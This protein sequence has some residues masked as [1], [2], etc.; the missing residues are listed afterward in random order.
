MLYKFTEIDGKSTR[1]PIPIDCWEMKPTPVSLLI[2]GWTAQYRAHWIIP[3]LFQGLTMLSSLLVYA[4][5]NLFML[6]AYGPLYGA[7]ASA[8]MM[9][10]RYVLSAAFPMF[11]LRMF[12]ALGQILS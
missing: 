7:S 10:S 3:I 1:H 6:D 9:L 11:A 12:Q 8:V 5:A 2:A 4:G